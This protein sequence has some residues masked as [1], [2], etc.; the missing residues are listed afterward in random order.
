MS[1]LRGNRIRGRETLYRRYA[2]STP[3]IPGA[4][5]ASIDTAS[6]APASDVNDQ[7]D[8]GVFLHFINHTEFTYD[9]PPESTLLPLE[10]ATQ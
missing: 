1:S 4:A 5:S 3:V 10:R 2:P 8:E 9:E 7:N 6:A